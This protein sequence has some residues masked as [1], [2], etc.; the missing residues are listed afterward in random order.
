[1]HEQRVFLSLIHIFKRLNTD[2]LDVLLIHRP[3]ALCEPS[4]IARAFEKLHSEGK[5][6]YFGV[7]NHN[8]MQVELLQ[9]YLRMPQMCIRDRF[10]SRP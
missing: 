2:Y 7:S 10:I 5:V 4:E 1:M 9:K 8:S 6:R 3:D